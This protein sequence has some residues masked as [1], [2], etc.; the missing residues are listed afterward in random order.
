MYNLKK[1]EFLL[2]YFSDLDVDV[3]DEVVTE[4]VANVHLLYLAVLVLCLDEHV[5]KE[6]VVM[7]L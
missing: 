4:V 3:S 7:F 5:L 2:S 6:V 1:N